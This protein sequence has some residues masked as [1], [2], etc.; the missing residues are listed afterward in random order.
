[1][2]FSCIFLL[3]LVFSG[4]QAQ[5]PADF[6]NFG[7]SANTFLINSSGVGFFSSGNVQLPNDYN[8]EFMSWQGFAI[9]TLTDTLTPGYPNEG[10]AIAGGGAEGTD[11]YAV[12]YAFS[13]Q[14]MQL[15][16]AA[17]GGVVQGLWVTNNAF[18]YYSMKDGDAFS[19]K[20]GGITGNDPDYFSLTIRKY[21]GGQL[22]SDSVV[23]FLSD[24]RF[25]NSSQDY[26]VKN[27]QYVDLTALGKADSLYF[28]LNSTDE[29]AF[30][31]NTPAYF[32]IDQVVTDD[33]TPVDFA[34]AP[35]VRVYP[36]PANDMAVFELPA[37]AECLSVVVTDLTGRVVF[38]QTAVSNLTIPTAQMP[39]GIYHVSAR[40]S[41]GRVQARLQVQH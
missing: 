25:S 17:A 6:E 8:P 38:E 21:L 40:T 32:C 34:K 14:N 27:W 5:T 2:R 41:V 37:G 20:F 31:M 4:V 15:I 33:F 35:A 39:G 29:G 7:L 19:K 11:T 13:P 30:G 1:M 23:F 12:S 26:I 28:E 16:G 24:F 9:S 22:S 3:F 18:A 36:N 10:S